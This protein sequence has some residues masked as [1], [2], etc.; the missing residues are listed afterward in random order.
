MNAHI[1]IT[2]FTDG[3]TTDIQDITDQIAQNLE[4]DFELLTNDLVDNTPII[5]WHTATILIR[6]AIKN[7]DFPLGTRR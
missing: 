1:T 5:I 7:K 6:D 3:P 2:T 4:T